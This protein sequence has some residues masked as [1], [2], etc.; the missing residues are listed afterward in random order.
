M[1]FKLVPFPVD[2]VPHLYL[3]RA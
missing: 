3:Q 1:N 2:E